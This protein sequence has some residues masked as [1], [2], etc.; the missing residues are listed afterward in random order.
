MLILACLS[1][2]ASGLHLFRVRLDVVASGVVVLGGLGLLALAP[3]YGVVVLILVVGAAIVSD[4]AD[5]PTAYGRAAETDLAGESVRPFAV[6]T[7]ATEP[8]ATESAATE[9]AATESAATEQ[10]E[11]LRARAAKARASRHRARAERIEEQIRS[12]SC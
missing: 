9:P 2:V 6:L 3:L 1:V 5:E 8:A 4:A 11:R 12:L 7:P 10:I